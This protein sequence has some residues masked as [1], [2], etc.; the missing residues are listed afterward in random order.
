MHRRPLLALLSRYD[1]RFP[2]E[3]AACARMRYFVEQHA[4]CFDRNL[5]KGHLTGSAWLVDRHREKVLLTHH[6]KLDRWLQPGG[7][8]DGET[9]MARVALREAC[10]ES[11]LEGLSLVSDDL[12]DI[13]IHLIPERGEEPAHF[14][15]DCRFLVR[16]DGDGKYRVSDESHDLAWVPMKQIVDYTREESILRMRM[17]SLGRV[18]R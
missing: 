6:R 3:G 2:D 10:E 1:H 15:F 5:E 16:C 12:F 18:F 11:G 13:D 17:K 9:D 7:H 14:H 8:A 4:D